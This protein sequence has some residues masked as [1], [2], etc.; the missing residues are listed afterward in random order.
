MVKFSATGMVW[1]NCWG[2]G[3]VGYAAHA[4]N[5]FD[6]KKAL[7]EE[8]EKRVKD[9][10]LDGGMGYESLEGVV[11]LITKTD[12]RRIGSKDFTHTEKQFAK[13]GN[14]PRGV[15]QDLRRANG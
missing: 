7:L 3:Q 10:S 12:T 8:A 4:L 14:I 13:V 1:G 2:G 11:L 9:G 6:T 5:D 15:A